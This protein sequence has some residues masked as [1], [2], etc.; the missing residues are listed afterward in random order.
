MPVV[1]RRCTGIKCAGCSTRWPLAAQFS[2]AAAHSNAAPSHSRRIGA[3]TPSS[4]IPQTHAEAVSTSG[5]IRAATSSML[6]EASTLCHSPLSTASVARFSSAKLPRTVRW[7]SSFS[8]LRQQR[9]TGVGVA[10]GGKKGGV[11]RQTKQ[12][13]GA[14]QAG[15]VEPGTPHYKSWLCSDRAPCFTLSIFR[16]SPQPQGPYRLPQCGSRR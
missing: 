16:R 8:Y 10:G 11:W 9:T 14:S 3:D 2:N 6:P 12:M 4:P 15:E 13:R 1:G 5:C 7:K